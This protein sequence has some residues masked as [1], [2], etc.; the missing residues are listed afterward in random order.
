MDHYFTHRG[1][2]VIRTAIHTTVQLLFNAALATAKQRSNFGTAV[3]QRGL[4]SV[5]P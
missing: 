2:A 5:Q 1:P 3:V 4:I